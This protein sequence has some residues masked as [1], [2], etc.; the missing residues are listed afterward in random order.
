MQVL[1]IVAYR[2]FVNER[3]GTKTFWGEVRDGRKQPQVSAG[4]IA[5]TIFYS[6]SMGHGS[7]LEMDNHLKE[8]DWAGVVLGAKRPIVYNTDAG[9]PLFSDSTASRSLR[10]MDWQ[11]LRERLTH[12]GRAVLRTVPEAGRV[13]EFRV[14]AI[15]Q[16]TI[17]GQPAVVCRLVG[18]VCQVNLDFEPLQK[19]DNEVE[20]AKRL[21]SRVQEGWGD[22]IDLYVVDGLYTEWFIER[23]QKARRR[24]KPAAQVVVKTREKSLKLTQ[25]VEEL[26]ARY[27]Q[28]GVAPIEGVDEDGY[29]SYRFLEFER[30]HDEALD[31]P[32][33]VV[34]VWEEQLKGQKLKDEYY[35]ITTL[36]KDQAEAAI[37]RAIGR[38]RWGIENSCFRRTK[39]NMNARH[40]FSKDENAACAMVALLL[41][42]D[43]ALEA[44]VVMRQRRRELKRSRK[45][46]LRFIMRL[47]SE[48]VPPMPEKD[49]EPHNPRQ[50]LLFEPAGTRAKSAPRST[51]SAQRG[52]AAA[53]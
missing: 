4:V 42:A 7:L 38:A 3:L 35:L 48:S 22:L 43:T 10:G 53:H 18:S 8:H 19:G 27:L 46:T 40:R 47:L 6:L 23:V 28:L 33:R 32:L 25:K 50:L 41:L 5:Q 11:K 1:N 9:K 15:D 26:T 31:Q 36:K 16:S 39:Q 52:V 17:A 44:F 24:G 14:A 37:V 2:D 13:G 34:K 21:L 49:E 30:I 12:Q 29:K 20:A 51:V 45:L